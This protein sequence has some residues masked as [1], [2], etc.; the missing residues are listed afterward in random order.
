M[1]MVKHRTRFI[2]AAITIICLTISGLPPTARA[3][4]TSIRSVT[5]VGTEFRVVLNDGRVL[6]QNELVGAVLAIG[7]G[8]G[9]QRKIRIDRVLKDPRDKDGEVTLYELF[10][11][12]QKTGAWAN[13]CLPDPDG[14]SYGFPLA[15]IWTSNDSHSSAPN[16]LF[17]ITCSSGSYGKC[18]RF[19][20]KPWRTLPDGTSLAPYYQ[21]CIHMV[22]ADYCGNGVAHTKNGTTIDMFDRIGIQTR[23]GGPGMVFE[24][25]WGPEGAVCVNHTRWPDLITLDQLAAECPRFTPDRLGANCTEEKAGILFNQSVDPARR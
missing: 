6:E 22:R 10:E 18:V 19:G 14:N 13:E 8:T 1:T 16:G 20:Y 23:E 21:A 11:Q 24:A 5:V 3:A 7:D 17:G 4:D 15:G 25:A 2:F 9:N 12:D